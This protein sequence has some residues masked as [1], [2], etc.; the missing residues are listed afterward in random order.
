MTNYVY[1]LHGPIGKR[2]RRH[3]I[4]FT[5]N[6]R[7]RIRQHNGEI[8]GGAKRTTRYSSDWSMVCLISGFSSKHMAL[9]YEWYAQH[10][11][12]RR[13]NWRKSIKKKQVNFSKYN[14]VNRFFYALFH[15][16]FQ[17]EKLVIRIASHLVK[18]SFTADSLSTLLGRTVILTEDIPNKVVS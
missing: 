10:D 7:R 1:F 13:Y 16:K 2:K 6:P 17:D 5:V 8:V 4:G 9:S 15:R 3:Y 11:K 12:G 14:Q 18:S